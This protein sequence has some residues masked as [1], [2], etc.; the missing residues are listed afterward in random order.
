MRTSQRKKVCATYRDDGSL[1]EDTDLD[2]DLKIVKTEI[3]IEDDKD[4]AHRGRRRNLCPLG[5]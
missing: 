3:S 4:A 5:I 1:P 2:V